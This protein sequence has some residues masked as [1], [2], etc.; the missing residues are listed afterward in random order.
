[1]SVKGVYATVTDYYRVTYRLEGEQELYEMDLA[2]RVGGHHN[3]VSR[4]RGE[5][6]ER[7]GKGK[8]GIMLK[9][10][11]VKPERWNGYA[12]D[13]AGVKV[14]VGEFLTEDLAWSGCSKYR[15]EHREEVASIC[16]EK[17]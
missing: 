8:F 5:V 4:F 11:V 13:K 3:I 10:D 1:M 14:H 6:R 9:L 15:R 2:F 16:V 17:G 7:H 12:I